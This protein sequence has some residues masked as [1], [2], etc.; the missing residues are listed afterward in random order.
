M[1]KTT[2]L[3][4]SLLAVIGLCWALGSCGSFIAFDN[5]DGNC[6]GCVDNSVPRTYLLTLTANQAATTKATYWAYDTGT[7]AAGHRVFNVIVLYDKSTINFT[8]YVVG[9]DGP[10]GTAD[11]DLRV[12]DQM[13]PHINTTTTFDVAGF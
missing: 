13:T 2:L 7:G 1:R 3:S 12:V 4:A 9:G 10:K 5:E 11:Y 8:S 6:F